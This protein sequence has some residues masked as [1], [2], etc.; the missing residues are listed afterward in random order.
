VIVAAP[1]VGRRGVVAGVGRD[2]AYVHD[3][4]FVVVLTVGRP[5]LPNGAQ[6]GRLPAVGS[7]VIVGGDEVWDATL[8]LERSPALPAASGLDDLVSAVR[9]RDPGLAA[10]AGARLIGRGPGLTPEGDDVVAGVAAVVAA[11]PWPGALREAWLGALVGDD[12]R[13][14][15]CALSATLLSLAVAGMG[16]EPLQAMLRGEPDALDR[17]LALGHSTGRA[18]AVGAGAGLL[19]VAMR[20]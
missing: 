14:R 2:A 11:G 18:Y 16:P 6:V 20:R 19:A 17:L 8:R 4:G 3:D 15:T 12:L 1:V 10:V 7:T 9:L 5:L 13:R